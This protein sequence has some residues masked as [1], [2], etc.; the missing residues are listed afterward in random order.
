MKHLLAFLFFI[1]FSFIGSASDISTSL[2]TQQEVDSFFTSVEGISDD[3]SVDSLT[4]ASLNEEKP[5]ADNMPQIQYNVDSFAEKRSAS[6]KKKTSDFDDLSQKWNLFQWLYLMEVSI[7]WSYAVFNENS[8]FIHDDLKEHVEMDKF[9]KK[10]LFFSHFHIDL[11]QFPYV[12][13]W[14]LK[15]GAGLSRNYDIRS[16]YFIP[17]S[18]SLIYHIRAIKELLPFVELGFS[19]WNIDFSNVFSEFYFFWSVGGKISFS[20]FKKSLRYTMPSDYGIYDIGMIT[21][22]RFHSGKQYQG[23]TQNFLK[24]FHVGLYLT[25]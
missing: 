20:L 24:T 7:Q 1:L 4:N 9:L 22:L 23:E 25:F 10:A 15:L 8:N 16:Y 13:S 5:E 18:F 21:E 2:F 11:I 19:S 17:L 3:S 6:P 12:L 14:G